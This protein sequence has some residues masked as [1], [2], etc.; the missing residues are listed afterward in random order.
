MNK[1]QAKGTS[2]DAKSTAKESSEKASKASTTEAKG[3]SDKNATTAHQKT[4]HTKEAAKTSEK[5]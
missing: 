3:K 2:K 5:R 1:D 4:G